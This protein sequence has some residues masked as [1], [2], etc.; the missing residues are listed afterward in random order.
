MGGMVSDLCDNVTKEIWEWCIERDLWLSAAHLPGRENMEADAASR[1]FNES[2]EWKLRH[3]IFTAIASRLNAQ[4]PRYASWKPDLGA[5]YVDA[6]SISWKNE[7][8]YAFPPFS[9]VL[10][11]LKKIEEEK[12]E[13]VLIIPNWSTKPW[14]PKLLHLLVDHPRLFPLEENLIRN[15]VNKELVHHLWSR[16]HL[17]A[18]KLPGSKFKNREHLMQLQTLSSS[19]GDWVQPS[20][21]MYTSGNGLSIAVNGT[22]IPL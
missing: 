8:F 14:Y 5:T 10:K 22:L 2:I 17:M 16:L 11:C 21:I 12:A 1:Q 15:P 19:H 13:G 6:F 3:D 7:N 18:C 20:T 9:L 4:L